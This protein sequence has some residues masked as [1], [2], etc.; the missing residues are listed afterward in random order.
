M[1]ISFVIFKSPCITLVAP[2][3][4]EKVAMAEYCNI[5]TEVFGVAP[6]GSMLFSL[7]DS[8]LLEPAGG[9]WLWVRRNAQ[10]VVCGA[11]LDGSR[12]ACGSLRQ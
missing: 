11:L 3:I 4:H 7:T 6:G 8:T 5:G 12:R 2:L 1:T 10:M 9:A